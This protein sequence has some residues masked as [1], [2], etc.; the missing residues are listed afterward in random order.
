MNCEL[1]LYLLTK[2]QLLYKPAYRLVLRPLPTAQ[3][4][5]QYDN[6]SHDTTTNHPRRPKLMILSL[7]IGN[8]PVIIY[9]ELTPNI[10]PGR[11]RRWPLAL[12]RPPR[13]AQNM[14]A[15]RY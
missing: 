5:H 15:I 7:F 12:H 3:N 1:E 10:V 11:D 8:T 4:G 2:A 9:W 13:T 14:S 6:N